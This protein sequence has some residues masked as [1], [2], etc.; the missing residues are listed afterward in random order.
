MSQSDRMV[1]DIQ[2]IARLYPWA[3][4]RMMDLYEKFKHAELKKGGMFY[5]VL[6]VRGIDWERTPPHIQEDGTVK[7]WFHKQTNVRAT[8]HG[9]TMWWGQGIATYIYGTHPVVHW[10]AIKFIGAL[11]PD[12]TSARFY[13]ELQLRRPPLET[14]LADVLNLLRIVDI[15]F[16]EPTDAQEH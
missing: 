12:G 7:V 6:D 2:S 9:I 15:Q 11:R 8:S 13:P 16:D 5:M 14:V 3:G 4:K 10:E 1:S